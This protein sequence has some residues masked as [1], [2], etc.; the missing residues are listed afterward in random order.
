MTPLSPTQ[1]ETHLQHVVQQFAQWRQSRPTPRGYRIPDPLW[2]EALSLAEVLSVPH[3]A[4]QLHLKP[5]ALKWRRRGQEPHA[6]AIPVL[7]SAALWRSRP[8]V[9]QSDD[10]SRNPAARWHPAPHHV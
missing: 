2:T 7:A 8:R 1:A 5:A 9:A 6:A 10:G 4:R 3:V